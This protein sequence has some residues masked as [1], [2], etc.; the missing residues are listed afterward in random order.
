M[1][2]DMLGVSLKAIILVVVIVASSFIA[3]KIINRNIDR[4]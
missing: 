3:L 1:E 2:A 4:K